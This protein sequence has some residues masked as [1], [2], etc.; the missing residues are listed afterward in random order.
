M[1]KIMV[2]IAAGMMVLSIHESQ[3]QRFSVATNM[4]EWASLGTMNIEGSYS[5][6][7]RWSIVAGARY[8][9]FSFRKAIPEKQF[10]LRQQSYSIGARIWP[11][12][13]WSGWWFAGKGR[14]QEYN[15][16]G[17]ISSETSEGDRAG[18]GL[19]AGYT[20]MLGPHLNIEFGLGV[21]GGLDWF[22]TYTCQICGVMVDEGR[23]TFVMPDDVMISLVYIF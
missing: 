7:R 3:A 1:K 16:G 8:N 18:V 13:T 23:K 22:R 2:L 14:Y 5:V 19:Y 15:F 11:W 6:S 9:P 10:Q 17:I 21:W 20:H 4:L 12:H